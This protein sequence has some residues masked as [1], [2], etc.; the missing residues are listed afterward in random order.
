[1][2]KL[3]IN[4]TI[5]KRYQFLTICWIWNFR[6]LHKKFDG[7]ERDQALTKWRI[8]GQKLIQNN[9]HKG[10]LQSGYVADITLFQSFELESMCCCQERPL[11]P[12]PS[13][14]Y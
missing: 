11:S 14:R 12:R 9:H 4:D 6:F 7:Y 10:L 8:N 2:E 1:M 5:C 3:L 13:Y